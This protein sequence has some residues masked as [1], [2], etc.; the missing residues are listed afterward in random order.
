MRIHFRD[1]NKRRLEQETAAQTRFGTANAATQGTNAGAMIQMSSTDLQR[2]LDMNSANAATQQRTTTGAPTNPPPPAAGSGG[3]H[4]C[5]TH[6]LSMN[7]N[8]T[9]ATCNCQA[10]GHQTAATLQNMMGGNNT[11]ARPRGERA[12]YCRP[13]R[14]ND[15]GN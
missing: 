12:I 6:G 9:S 2:L 5:W 14:P 4:Y 13:Q 3:F 7:P 10:P 11:I 1:A 15:S 8:H